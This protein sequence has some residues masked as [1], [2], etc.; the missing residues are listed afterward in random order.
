MSWPA[1]CVRLREAIDCILAAADWTAFGRQLTSD[2]GQGS[3]GELRL[4][5]T[6]VSALCRRLLQCKV[7]CSS[8]AGPCQQIF[9]SFPSA[10]APC[11]THV[12]PCPQ[13]FASACLLFQPLY[14]N[15]EDTHGKDVIDSSTA[16]DMG[17]WLLHG[18]G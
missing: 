1:V 5:T 17:L 2:P 6:K 18:Q 4:V 13:A 8:L 16:V 3:V 7:G 12:H 10:V 14:R 15:S 9:L 11:R